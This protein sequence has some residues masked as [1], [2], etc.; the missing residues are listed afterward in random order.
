MR[1]KCPRRHG[2]NRSG[3]CTR[4]QALGL[5]HLVRHPLTSHPIFPETA[6]D[7]VERRPSPSGAVVMIIVIL[8]QRVRTREEKARQ[9][10][11]E[12]SSGDAGQPMINA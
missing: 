11:R 10:A 9:E 5:I 12:R 4:H 1:V 8:A 6:A 2:S 3:S 7:M